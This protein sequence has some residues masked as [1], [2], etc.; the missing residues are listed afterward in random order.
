MFIPIASQLISPI[1]FSRPF[2]NNLDIS[3]FSKY[4]KKYCNMNVTPNDNTSYYFHE[5][6]YRYG[7]SLVVFSP[8]ILRV[9]SH[10]GPHRTWL[11][12]ANRYWSGLP[13]TCV[14]IQSMVRIKYQRSKNAIRFI[15]D[16][17]LQL[18]SV[19]N[20]KK[21]TKKKPI[22]VGSYYTAIQPTSSSNIFSKHFYICSI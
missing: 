22:W 7:D 15:S 3:S 10:T 20:S 18:F 12:H 16:V 11:F 5:T 6:I 4:L 13:V 2:L 19:K 21:K 1:K 8:T 14:P 9:D 17:I